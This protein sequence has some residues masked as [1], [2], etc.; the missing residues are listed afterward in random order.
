[1][2]QAFRL[3]AKLDLAMV[4]HPAFA[5][6]GTIAALVGWYGTINRRLKLIAAI[7]P[8]LHKKYNMRKGLLIMVAFAL[9]YCCVAQKIGKFGSDLGMKTVLGKEL[10]PPY[11][12][13]KSYYGYIVPGAQA[14]EEKGGKKYY[15][16]YV[17]IPVAAPE[18]G[19]RMISPVPDKMKPE[20]GDFVNEQYTK[21]EADNQGYFDTWVTLERAVN[22]LSLADVKTK[23]KSANW[24][25]LG[26]NDDSNELPEQPSGLKYNSVLRVTSSLSDPLKAITVGLYRIGFTTF[27]TGTVQGGFVAQIGAPISEFYV[28]QDGVKS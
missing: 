8:H 6:I 28:L 7:N 15:Y 26:Y 21:N 9:S 13:V 5:G 24:V 25:Q 4:K 12:E 20:T 19:I 18:I 22:I 16:V 11:S 17:W 3:F 27:K 2:V 23:I 1:M 10:R 14:D